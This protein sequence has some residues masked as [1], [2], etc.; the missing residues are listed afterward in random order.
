VAAESGGGGLGRGRGLKESGGFL[1]LAAFLQKW[2]KKIRLKE[3][4]WN[5]SGWGLM[6][7]DFWSDGVK[8]DK[9]SSQTG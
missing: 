8:E 5:A 3:K 6:A 9:K 7:G 2:R 1:D 4:L